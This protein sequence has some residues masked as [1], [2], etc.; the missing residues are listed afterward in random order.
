M[1]STCPKVRVHVGAS[2]NDD[3]DDVFNNENGNAND[4]GTVDIFGT[5][6]NASGGATSDSYDDIWS[7]GVRDYQQQDAQQSDIQN[8]DQNYYDFLSS[9]ADDSVQEVDTNNTQGYTG[10]IDTSDL[11]ALTRAEPSWDNF[12]LKKR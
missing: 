10:S 7:G 5:T 9:L 12:D 4:T 6:D 3:D 8:E 2:D 1:T 11:D